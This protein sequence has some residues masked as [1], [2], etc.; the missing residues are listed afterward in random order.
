M[1]RSW[2]QEVGDA[3]SVI[4]PLVRALQPET[5][6]E[7]DGAGG[8]GNETVEVILKRGDREARC[9][10]TFEAW[11]EARRDAREMRDAFGRIIAEMSE[12]K[13][14]PTFVLT[15]RGLEGERSDR[16]TEELRT[17]A[18]SKE[19]EAVAEPLIKKKHG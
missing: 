1:V 15:S 17:I 6:V 7:I 8:F 11:E 19:A 18:A 2:T 4:E 14:A 13:P 5:V 3:R 16:A 9:V 10:V 12:A